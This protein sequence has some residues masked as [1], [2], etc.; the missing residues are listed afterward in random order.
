MSLFLSDEILVV[1]Y[2]CERRR[3]NFL[4][5]DGDFYFSADLSVNVSMLIV[6]H[7]FKHEE[8][9]THTDALYLNYLW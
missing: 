4:F 2:E 5:V 1:V 3:L 7:L 9:A 8:K 6:C